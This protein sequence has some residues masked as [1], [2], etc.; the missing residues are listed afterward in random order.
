MDDSNTTAPAPKK[1]GRK[2]KNATSNQ[3]LNALLTQNVVI[4]NQEVTNEQNTEKSQP[5]KRGRKPK[6]GKIVVPVTQPTEVENT[7]VNVIM[8]LKCS[9]KDLQTS[10]TNETSL[11]LVT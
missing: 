8:H 4:D 7:K 1:R 9:L 6:G 11:F 10:F 5:K 2:P 3:D